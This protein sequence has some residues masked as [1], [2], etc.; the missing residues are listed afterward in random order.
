MQ[1]PDDGPEPNAESE[2]EEDHRDDDER[3]LPVMASGEL[4]STS[5]TI[6]TTTSGAEPSSSAAVRRRLAAAIPPS[7]AARRGLRPSRSMR[8][9]ERRTT[10]TLTC[11]HLCVWRGAVH[12]RREEEETAVAEFISRATSSHSC[13]ERFNHIITNL[14]IRRRARTPA[15][16]GLAGRGK[17]SSS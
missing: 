8:A 11:S 1:Q 9:V 6:A 17:C 4:L 16:R 12:T 3:H 5:E 7:D 14:F 13:C 15:A 2:H 10:S